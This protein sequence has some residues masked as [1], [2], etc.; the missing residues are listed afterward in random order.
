[1]SSPPK[2]VVEAIAVNSASTIATQPAVL[3]NQALSNVIASMNLANQ[4]AVAHQ[5]MMNQLQTAMVAK[6]ISNIASSAPPKV[7]APPAVSFSA[8][9]VAKLRALLAALGQK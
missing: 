9:E 3:A 4:N 1:M 5:Q 8:E 2:D 6:L 7:E